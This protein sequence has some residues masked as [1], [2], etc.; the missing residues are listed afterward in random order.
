MLGFST[1][2]YG[3]KLMIDLILTAT[4]IWISYIQ[5]WKCKYSDMDLLHPRLK[6]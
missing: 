3:V 1:P 6:V 5:D 2:T 4:L